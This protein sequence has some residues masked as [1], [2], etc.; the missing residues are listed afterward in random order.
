MPGL[1]GAVEAS[2]TGCR[3]GGTM[4]VASEA[5]GPGFL[6]VRSAHV[7]R[8]SRTIRRLSTSTTF[9]KRRA[10]RAQVRRRGHVLKLRTTP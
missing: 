8:V 5:D 10:G 4:R 7:L 3:L 6:I 1:L 2:A 9:E